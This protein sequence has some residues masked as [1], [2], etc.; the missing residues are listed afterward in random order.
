MEQFRI[1]RG[2]QITSYQETEDGFLRIKGTIAQ[3]GW[4][5]YLNDDGSIRLEY[6]SEEALFDKKHLDSL[7]IMPITLGHPEEQVTPDNY[8]KYSVGST[9]SHV[10]AR[11]DLGTVEI[12]TVTCARKAIDAIKKDKI[13]DLS[14]GY[15]CQ[16]VERGDGK[17]NQIK[18][19]GNHGAI[20]DEGRA[21]LARLYYDG[22][23]V[24]NPV[25]D[26]IDKPIIK[27]YLS[28]IDLSR[29]PRLISTG[30]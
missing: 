23:L 3:V 2:G 21:P 19:I 8:Q 20:V 11:E 17:Y 18:R 6:V 5:Q 9:G 1:D 12:I 24:G 7:G 26:S 13:R 30:G 10:I 28:A 4:L 16:V 29:K 15:K 27:V 25:T 22:F 14:E